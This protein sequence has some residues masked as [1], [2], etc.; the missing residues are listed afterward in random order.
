MKLPWLLPLELYF[1]EQYQK[2]DGFITKNTDL[3]I[4]AIS[5]SLCISDSAFIYAFNSIGGRKSFE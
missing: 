4:L 5:H 3:G 1:H 2:D